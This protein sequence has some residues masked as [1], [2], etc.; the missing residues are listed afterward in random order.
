LNSDPKHLYDRRFS[1]NPTE[2]DKILELLFFLIDSRNSRKMNKTWWRDSTPNL[3]HW[4]PVLKTLTLTVIGCLLTLQLWLF[5][6]AAASATG[7]YDLPTVAAGEPTWLVDDADVVSRVGKGEVAK[8]LGAIAQETGSEIRFVTIYRLEY[9]ETSQQLA[10]KL[11]D[12]WF[13]TPEEQQNQ[14]L[15]VSDDLTKTA[16]IRVADNLKAQISDETAKSIA[17]ETFLA[18]LR[19]GDRYN[20]AFADTSDRI[21][22]ILKGEPDPGPPKLEVVKS[23]ERTYAKAEETDTQSSTTILIVLLV[24]ATVVP[25]V[26]YYLYVR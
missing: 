16:G 23:G 24:V 7:V 1:L 26:T 13:P 4:N 5:Y 14:I 18:P 19:K 21:S 6:P 2:C 22:T 15:V 3:T 10:E 25:M 8:Q 17:Q 20:Q 9:D 12:K 11:F